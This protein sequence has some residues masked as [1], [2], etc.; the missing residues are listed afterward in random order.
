MHKFE[1][2]MQMT[3]SH[4]INWKRASYVTVQGKSKL[5]TPLHELGFPLD[6]HIFLQMDLKNVVD[7]CYKNRFTNHVDKNQMSN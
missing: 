5:S 4:I 3:L 1:I 7:W 2:Q 6:C